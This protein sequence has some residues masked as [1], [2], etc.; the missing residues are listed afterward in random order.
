MNTLKLHFKEFIQGGFTL[1]PL[2]L[3]L[4]FQVNCPGC[5][6]YAFPTFNK[7]YANLGDTNI[8]FLGLST[9]FEDFEKNTFENTRKLIEKGEL[10]GETKKAMASNNT[11]GLPYPINFPVAMDEKVTSLDNTEEAVNHV[12]NLNPNYKIW[13]GFEQKALQQKVSAYL[14]SLDYISLT[15]T[16]NQLRGTPSFILFNSDYQILND[17]FGMVEYEEVVK[18][19]ESHRQISAKYHKT[20]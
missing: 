7:L 10:I 13:P 16:L 14:N 11:Q 6:F 18:S 19:I 4:V 8:S 12:C 9:A 17:W 20:S 15:F 5:F 2:N 3:L 1:K